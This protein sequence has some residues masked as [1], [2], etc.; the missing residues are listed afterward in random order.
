MNEYN[1]SRECVANCLVRDVLGMRVK[2]FNAETGRWRLGTIIRIE[3]SFL[4]IRAK[5]RTIQKVQWGFVMLP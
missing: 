1:D 4:H 3:R 2:W 5:D